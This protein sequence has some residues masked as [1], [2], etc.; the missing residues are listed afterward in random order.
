[1]V[2]VNLIKN[3]YLFFVNHNAYKLQTF[4]SNKSVISNQLLTIAVRE[5]I[6]YYY[7]YLM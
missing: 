2:I 6:N 5:F 3:I 1:M 7:G 4:D